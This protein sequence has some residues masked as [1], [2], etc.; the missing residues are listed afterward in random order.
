MSDPV[1]GKNQR[2]WYWWETFFMSLNLPR[3]WE[4]NYSQVWNLCNRTKQWW[5]LTFMC[6]KK[7]NRQ[8]YWNN[9]RL[10]GVLWQDRQLPHCVLPR[11]FSGAVPK[12]TLGLMQLGWWLNPQICVFS[13]W[14][15]VL[16]ST[17]Y[18]WCTAYTTARW[19]LAH[20]GVFPLALL[21]GATEKQPLWCGDQH[22][23]DTVQRVSLFVRLESLL[24][25]CRSLSSGRHLSVL[26]GVVQSVC[27]VWF[28]CE[29][30]HWNNVTCSPQLLNDCGNSLTVQVLVDVFLIFLLCSLFQM[31]VAET[32]WRSQLFQIFLFY[33]DGSALFTCNCLFSN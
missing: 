33:F 18:E 27:P 28:C 30:T 32:E 24:L 23:Y 9:W 7:K 2:R 10:F 17:T 5:L 14:L 25:H 19:P 21:S 13:F 12:V 16:N 6:L 20:L 3:E 1:A 4:L 15:S 26:W 31:G 22:L 29:L 8:S 11:P